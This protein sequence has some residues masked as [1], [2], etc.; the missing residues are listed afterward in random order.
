MF[1]GLF[2]FCIAFNTIQ[3]DN[4]VTWNTKIKKLLYVAFSIT[5]GAAF[6]LNFF[7]RFPKIDTEKNSIRVI[8]STD[9]NKIIDQSKNY[10][11][12]HNFCRDKPSKVIESSAISLSPI[13]TI[14]KFC[15][16]K[17]KGETMY[18]ECSL[19]D[20]VLNQELVN[21][22]RIT[23]VLYILREK[24]SRASAGSVDSVNVVSEAK[25]QF[26]VLLHQNVA[27]IIASSLPLCQE[28]HSSTDHYTYG[29]TDADYQDIYHEVVHQALYQAMVKDL[30]KRGYT[31]VVNNGS[32][33]NS[34]YWV[35]R[36]LPKIDFL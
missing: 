19:Y 4:P 34:D 3:C 35:A 29:H 32:T 9:C 18:H 30:K 17:D 26:F 20:P 24:E 22:Y 10:N 27:T 31:I 15:V 14:V 13:K 28:R 36:G 33:L 1:G 5:A 8:D 23:P 11:I 21:H 16:T 6:L 12:D 25:A 2:L 7:L